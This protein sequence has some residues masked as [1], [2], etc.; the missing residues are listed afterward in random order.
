[1]ADN[2]EHYTQEG[3][4]FVDASQPNAVEEA[5]KRHHLATA[6]PDH[7]ADGTMTGPAHEKK[8]GLE[9]HDES[10]AQWETAGVHPYENR[11]LLP[12]EEGY[13]GSMQEQQVSAA[14]LETADA[15]S[16]DKSTAAAPRASDNK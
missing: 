9:R 14:S 4:G 1:M 16:S 2:Q 8:Y 6:D 13:E 10:K 5:R 3:V 7:D 15:D 11:A 12:G